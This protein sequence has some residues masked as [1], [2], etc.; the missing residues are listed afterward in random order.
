MWQYVI[1]YLAIILFG[2]FLFPTIFST[3]CSCF[4]K[5]PVIFGNPCPMSIYDVSKMYSYLSL[6]RQVDLPI[7]FLVIL[8]LTT[9]RTIYFFIYPLCMRTKRCF[10]YLHLSVRNNTLRVM[11]RV[12]RETSNFSTISAYVKFTIIILS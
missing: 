11:Y 2:C 6:K 3:C 7:L 5:F 9:Y 8:I 10:R 1:V 12:Q 4:S